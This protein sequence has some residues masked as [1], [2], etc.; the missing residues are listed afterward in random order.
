MTTVQPD[1]QTNN[2]QQALD[3][4]RSHGRLTLILAVA[5]GET[6]GILYGITIEPLKSHHAAAALIVVGM[7]IATT[8]V[9]RWGLQSR[10]A[11]DAG[12]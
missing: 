4:S 10:A 5:A 6:A 7:S 2:H 1:P 8:I 9:G 12:S 11:I 3:R